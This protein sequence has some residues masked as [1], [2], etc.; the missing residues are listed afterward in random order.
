MKI[1]SLEDIKLKYGLDN[2]KKVNDNIT[3]SND[4]SQDTCGYSAEELDKAKTRVLKYLMYK[5]RT[6]NEVRVKFAK[7]I[8]KNLL[9]NVIEELKTARIYK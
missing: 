6:E 1:V 9:D 2:N 3:D 7:D 5:K 8:N 4:I